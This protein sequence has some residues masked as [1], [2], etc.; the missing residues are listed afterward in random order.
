[1]RS[2][3]APTLLGALS[4]NYFYSSKYHF[5]RLSI[6]IYNPSPNYRMTTTSSQGS[7]PTRAPS[8]SEQK[9]IDDVLKLYQLQPSEQAY[10]HYSEDAVFRRFHLKRPLHTVAFVQLRLS[11]PFSTAQR[12][13]VTATENF[14]LTTCPFF[15]LLRKAITLT[16][17]VPHV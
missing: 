2:T 8:A 17:N 11:R 14:V 1:M 9:L 12:K 13:P 5:R 7:H 3:F 10:S 6:F 16:Q 4:R 15:Y